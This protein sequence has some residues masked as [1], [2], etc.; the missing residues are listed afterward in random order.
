MKKM[1]SAFCALTAIVGGA[2]AYSSGNLSP[3][4][5]PSANQPVQMSEQSS[6][7]TETATGVRKLDRNANTVNSK[8]LAEAKLLPKAIRQA[9]ADTTAADNS[10]QFMREDLWNSVENIYCFNKGN[11]DRE[12]NILTFTTEDGQ[13]QQ[14]ITGTDAD[15]QYYRWYSTHNAPYTFSGEIT[16]SGEAQVYPCIIYYSEGWGIWS[17]TSLLLNED[18]GLT[19]RFEIESNAPEGYPLGLAFIVEAEAGIEITVKDIEFYAESRAAQP[20]TE[21]NDL[22]GLGIKDNIDPDNAYIYQSEDGLTTFGMVYDGSLWITGINTTATTV[23]LPEQVAFNGSFL[24]I[25]GVGYG[26]FDYSGAQTMEVLDM[27]MVPTMSVRLDGF[28]NLTDVYIYAV[29]SFPSPVS[30]NGKTVYLHIPLGLKRSDYE[31]YGFTRVLVGNEAHDCPET[32]VSD[33]V[34]S[35]GNENEYFGATLVNGTFRI[36]E[37]FSLNDTIT[38]PDAVPFNNGSYVVNSLG[39]ESRLS[40]GTLTQHAPS[41][42]SIRVPECYNMVYTNWSYNATLTE[43]HME[44]DVPQTNNWNLPSRMTVYVNNQSYYS[45]Y[46][47]NSSWNSAKLLPEG[48][49]FDWMVVNVTR[50]GELAQTYIEMTDADWGAGLYVKVTGTLNET[51]LNNI[52]NMTSL[53]KLDLSEAEFTS[54]PT[55]FLYNSQTIEEVILPETLTSIPQYAF[56]SCGKL[57]KVIADG[58]TS[59]GEQAFNY[60]QNLTSLDTSNVTYFG[61]NALYYCQQLVPAINENTRTI[62]T[63]AFAYTAIQE[64]IIPETITSIASDAF[65]YCTKL[66]KVVIPETVTV[67]NSGAFRECRNLTDLTIGEGVKTIGNSAFNN[68]DNL[69]E[70]TFPSTV[71]SIGS[72]AIANCDKL[73]SVKCKAVVPPV[74]N[75]QFTSGLDLN[76]CTLYVAPFAIDAYREANNW[77][78]FYIIKPLDEPVKN[79]YIE[80]PMSFNLMSEDNAVLQDNPNM[81]LAYNTGNNTVGEL[82]AEGDGTLSAGVFTL[83]HSFYRRTSYYNDYRTTLVN[84]AENMRADSVACVIDFEKNYWHFISFQYDVNMADI[85]GLNNTDFVIREYN[86]ERRATGDGSIS[87]WDNVAADGVLKAGKGYI[88]Q[89]ANN[90]TNSNGNTYA[91]QIVFP[92]RNTVTKNNLFTSNNIIVPLEEHAAEFAHNRSW[93]LVGNPYPC[94]Y[95]VPSLM[96]DFSTPIVIWRG[97]GYQAYSPVDD[98]IV[99]RPNE[100]FFVQRPLDAGEMVFGAEGRMHYTEAVDDNMNPGVKAPARTAAG[101][102]RSVFNFTVSGCGSDNRTR[103]VM[104]EEAL[105][106]Y[107]IARDATKFFAEKAEGVEVFVDAEIRYDICERPLGDGTA[108]LGARFA[109]DGEYTLSLSGRGIIGWTVVLT[110]RLT[111]KTVDL[112]CEDYSFTAEAGSCEGRFMLSFG[113]PDQS[114]VEA[115]AEAEGDSVVKVVTLAGV[116]LFEGRMADFT[117][118]AP[119]VY[120]VAGAEKAY[121]VVVK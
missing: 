101:S 98:D 89:A 5:M 94:Y 52:K 65:Y 83:F 53:R 80:K 34:F 15:I 104:N 60:C 56:Y 10:G 66:S 27:R 29:T 96:E 86:S 8:S 119:G 2:V 77:K 72:G 102:E 16:S 26:S 84:N 92:S 47:Q 22:P 105:A 118:P 74:A 106:E 79:I 28:A 64:A 4:G 114:S 32:S 41:L 109:T 49:E 36:S 9:A 40:S 25:A 67:I 108:M 43:L 121:K 37:I 19:R 30:L 75:S 6:R 61:R 7:A 48:W 97:T 13:T 90:T 62:G 44:G 100:A 39:D 58:I 54:L 51:D 76:H 20:W 38:L 120:I 46:E 57:T 115:V 88:L 117:A 14:L 93:N 107:E 95:Y 87:N 31:H 24:E 12:A 99:L 33:Y 68:C 113:S 116:T 50:K 78:D 17:G 103:I 59:I 81:T 45:N 3:V 71:T 69:A 23:T 42:K 82:S 91:A 63:G 55:E 73:M 11:F 35:S 70:I 18:Y 111:G 21:E 112:T 85:T 1:L 110:D